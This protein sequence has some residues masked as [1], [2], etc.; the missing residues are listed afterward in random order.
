MYFYQWCGSGS[1]SGSAGSGRFMVEADVEMEAPKNMQLPLPV[2][3]KVAVQIWVDSCWLEIFSLQFLLNIH[4]NSSKFFLFIEN[5]VVKYYLTNYKT[6]L[7]IE[8]Q[9]WKSR[10]GSTSGSA[11]FLL[12]A[13]APEV[14]AESEAVRVKAEALTIR[15]LPHHWFLPCVLLCKYKY[16]LNLCYDYEVPYF[17]FFLL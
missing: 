1:G 2:C 17:H 7:Q 11:Y 16:F 14:E 13:G 6:N 3:L 4:L 8:K 10:S 12:E 5:N 9:N 15:P